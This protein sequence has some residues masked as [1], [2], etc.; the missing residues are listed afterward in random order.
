MSLFEFV[1]TLVLFNFLC[2]FVLLFLSVHKKRPNIFINFFF[3]SIL[4][5]VWLALSIQQI[6]EVAYLS[7][8]QIIAN[9]LLSLWVLSS[10]YLNNPLKHTLLQDY[11]NTFEQAVINKQPKRIFVLTFYVSSV[12]ILCF[13]PI[14]SLNFLSGPSSFYFMDLLSSII[15]IL[16]MFF[17]LKSN[18]KPLSEMKLP[19]NGFFQH[20]LLPYFFGNLF[21]FLGLFLLSTNATGGLW[22]IIGPVTMLFLLVKVFS[23]KNKRE[24]SAEQTTTNL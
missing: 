4:L 9:V 24:L 10:V 1:L 16:G 13:S 15:C 20:V 12:Q 5:S 18:K 14:V 3:L 23:P 19:Y 11:L 22:S 2:I 6:S 21:F 7:S 8:R 17:H